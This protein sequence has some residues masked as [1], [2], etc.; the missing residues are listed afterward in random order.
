MADIVTPRDLSNELVSITND[1]TLFEIYNPDQSRNE[2][3][4]MSTL[5]SYIAASELAALIVTGTTILARDSSEVLI[6]TGGA[7]VKLEVREIIQSKSLDNTD[8]AKHGEIQFLS[9]VDGRESKITGWRGGSSNSNGLRLITYATGVVNAMTIEP[10]GNV[11]LLTTLPGQIFDINQGSG[12]M[13][14]DGYDNHSLAEYKEDI[15][16]TT[17]DYLKNLADCPPKI[18]KRKPHIPAEGIRDA[19]IEEFGAVTWLQYFP[20]DNY[21]NGAIKNMPASSMKTWIDTW[22]ENKR[23]E[24]RQEPKWQRDFVGLVADDL[25]LQEKLPEVIAVNDEGVTSGISLN[26]YIGVLHVA[27]IQLN[28]RI[29][30]LE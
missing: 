19:A 23:I 10:A 21:S 17:V 12:N 18:W 2:K 9:D 5:L 4:Q 6:G 11:G 3:V 20:K 8:N 25:T 27:I 26:D 16:D 24:M 29:K 13:I 22:C 15:K 7:S 30:Q 14:A 1:A 28:D